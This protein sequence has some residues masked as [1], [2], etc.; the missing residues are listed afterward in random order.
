MS[1]NES[2]VGDPP[3]EQPPDE[4]G[5]HAPKNYPPKRVTLHFDH[6]VGPHQNQT[7]T[8]KHHENVTQILE[9]LGMPTDGSLVIRSNKQNVD[10]AHQDT[11][12]EHIEPGET[13][14]VIKV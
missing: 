1:V 8:I 5:Q 14:Q 7:A 13:V 4:G 12:W 2:A 10:L 3:D 11:V 6:L 9:R